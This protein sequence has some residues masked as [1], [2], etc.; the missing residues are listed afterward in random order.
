ML[1]KKN[2]ESSRTWGPVTLVSNLAG[3]E[4][5]ADRDMCVQ[6]P[7][8][9]LLDINLRESQLGSLQCCLQQ[10]HPGARTGLGSQGQKSSKSSDF[11]Q[12]GSSPSRENLEVSSVGLM[13]PGLLLS[14]SCPMWLP[15]PRSS[16]VSSRK[17]AKE[18]GSHLPALGN[19]LQG[20]SLSPFHPW[21]YTGTWLQQRLPS[22]VL[23]LKC[24]HFAKTRGL[25]SLEGGRMDARGHSGSPVRTTKTD[26]LK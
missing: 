3:T 15:L 25:V 19:I 12:D 24:L 21:G 17:K 13:G 18:R 2:P 20:A 5:R 11:K 4:E 7:V 22:A 9:P 23:T 8:I 26:I 1:G 16:C 6:W 10:T 14:L